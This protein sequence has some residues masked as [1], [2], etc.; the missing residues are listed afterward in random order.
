M[1]LYTHFEFLYRQK[2]KDPTSHPD[3]T[4]TPSTPESPQPVD[5]TKLAV[6]VDSIIKT[7]QFAK[8]WKEKTRERPFSANAVKPLYD[9]KGE[10]DGKDGGLDGEAERQH[11]YTP[12]HWTKVAEQSKHEKVASF[13]IYYSVAVNKY[14]L[15]YM[16]ILLIIIFY[17]SLYFI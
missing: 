10:G 7:R 4:D 8:L 14:I 5:K 1:F 11:E 17:I 9:G 16:Y 15:M 6:R 12:L 13:F 2:D 3:S